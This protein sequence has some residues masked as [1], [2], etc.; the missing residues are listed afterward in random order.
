MSTS[1]TEG[2]PG[3]LI[4]AALSGVP[5][6]ATDVGFVSETVGPGG[7]LV[8]PD[9]GPDEI[10]VVVRTTLDSAA[11]FGPLARRHAVAQLSWNAI[12]P[13]WMEVVAAVSPA[14]PRYGW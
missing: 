7:V 11:R 14:S 2:M 5:V 10:A 6:V 12:A 1:S 9:A 8:R 4:E 13:A 3:S